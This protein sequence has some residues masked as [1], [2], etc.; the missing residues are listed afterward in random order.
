MTKLDYTITDPV[1]RN[2][3]VKKILEEVP[4]P[5]EAYLE[6]LSNYLILCIDKEEKRQKKLLTENR[7]ATINRRETS[8]EGLVAQLENGEDGLYNLINENNKQTIFK[9]KISITQ[10]DVEE[11]PYLKQLREAIHSLEQLSKNASGRDAFILKKTIID[12]RKDQYIIKD[13]YR[14]P[15]NVTTTRSMRP[16]IHFDDK[17][18]QFN[19]KDGRPIPEGFSL[20]NPKVCSAILC[21]YSDLKEIS[22]DKLTEDAYYLMMDFDHI[23]ARALAGNELYTRL[24][25]LKID[26]LTNIQIQQQLQ[27]EFGIKHSLEYISSLWRNKIPRMIAFAA[28]AEYL[29]HYYLNVEKG[30]YKRCSCCGQIKLAHNNYFSKNKTSKDGYYSICKDCRNARAK[31]KGGKENA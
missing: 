25:E 30:Q 23:S 1:Q 22:W 16:Y 11:I 17:T 9:P 29:D 8:Y 4:N 18:H 3:L 7:M 20:M 12:L 13:T 28:E 31:M 2:E 26:G 10:T 15:V 14:K 19:P 6:S 21:N 5:S 24:V 27:E